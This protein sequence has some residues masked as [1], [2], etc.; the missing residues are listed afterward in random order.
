[1]PLGRLRSTD[2]LTSPG[3][4]GSHVQRLATAAGSPISAHRVQRAGR[5][6]LTTTTKPPRAAPPTT[7]TGI[8]TGWL[9]PPNPR[10]SCCTSSP[11]TWPELYTA[12]APALWAPLST[13]DPGDRPQRGPFVA[14][15]PHADAATRPRPNLQTRHARHRPRRKPVTLPSTCNSALT[16]SRPFAPAPNAAGE[17]RWPAR[18]V[19]PAVRTDTSARS[20]TPTDRPPALQL[21]STQ[22]LYSSGPSPPGSN[23]P[24]ALIGL[25]RPGN[26]DCPHRAAS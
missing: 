20:P 4:Y 26:S 6:G 16:T 5:P 25:P 13:T 11:T 2:G 23:P 21:P 22:C 8:I 7:S 14:Q 9:A 3:G 1:M 19:L 24:P 18:C 17:T 15:S 12:T 10:T